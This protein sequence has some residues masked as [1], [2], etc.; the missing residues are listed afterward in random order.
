MLAGADD[1]RL[2]DSSIVTLAPSGPG[3]TVA[4]VQGALVLTLPSLVAGGTLD[5][6]LA[7]TWV[8]AGFAGV[9][10]GQSTRT[11]SAVVSGSDL[12]PANDGASATITLTA[13]APV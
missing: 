1:P 8:P 6:A 9:G 5:I 3:V 11:W 7:P 12:S 13:G 10:A 2:W 4:G